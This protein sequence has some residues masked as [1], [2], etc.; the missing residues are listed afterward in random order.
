MTRQNICQSIYY[1]N[2]Q[3]Y[4]K[5]LLFYYQ[6]PTF[7][8]LPYFFGLSYFFWA[9]LR[10]SYFFAAVLLSYFFSR[11]SAGNPAIMPDHLK[12]VIMGAFHVASGLSESYMNLYPDWTKHD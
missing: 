9:V 12:T 5:V 3:I 1:Y 4:L 10:D 11:K 7:F 2:I 6:I 8:G